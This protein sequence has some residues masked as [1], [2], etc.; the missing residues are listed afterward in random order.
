[1][2]N[3]FL[4]TEMAKPFKM[5]I[6][7]IS[8]LFLIVACAGTESGEEV[9]P[10]SP[11][12]ET[13]EQPAAAANFCDRLKTTSGES[14][15]TFSDAQAL[16]GGTSWQLRE[17]RV[18]P[19]GDCWL[20]LEQAPFDK[21]GIRTVQGPDKNLFNLYT[22]G[23]IT[24][25]QGRFVPGVAEKTYFDG[26]GFL[27]TKQGEHRFMITCSKAGPERT[28]APKIRCSD[29]EHINIAKIVLSRVS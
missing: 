22:E 8:L 2:L 13:N 28:R 19:S 10:E 24:A 27:W 20:E 9:L 23:E 4:K 17:T 26:A 7:L 5:F 16:L 18:M 21:I 25:D 1:M 12:I 3:T 11:R 6:F 14:V 15:F 29:E